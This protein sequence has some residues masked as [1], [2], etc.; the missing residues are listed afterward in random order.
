M[1]RSRII[2]IFDNEFAK[3]G[4]SDSLQQIGFVLNP[5]SLQE[6]APARHAGEIQV[7]L[8]LPRDLDITIGQLRARFAHSTIIA[9]RHIES[10]AMRINALLAG[11]DSCYDANISY[12]EVAAA[13]QSAQRKLTLCQPPA[14]SVPRRPD[15]AAEPAAA[16]QSWRLCDNEWTLVSPGGA[17][18]NLTPMERTVLKGMHGHPERVIRRAGFAA[19]G[20]D[21]VGNGRALDLV[22]SRLKRKGV[23]AGMA[24]PI[25]SLRGKGYAFSATLVQDGSGA[26]HEPT[27]IRKEGAVSPLLAAIQGDRLRFHYQPIVTAADLE[28]VGAEALLR[29]R[30]AGG[31][32]MGIDGLLREAAAPE[33]AQALISW[34]LQT[35][36][37]DQARWRQAAQGAALAVNLNIS[38]QSFARRDVVGT[39]LR[40]IAACGQASGDIR[41]ELTEEAALHAGS[42]DI[43]STLEAFTGRGIQVWLDDFG[44][45]YNN[46][47]W[48]STLPL[49]GLKLDK[50]IV[51]SAARQAEAQKVMTS[52]C[53]LARDLDIV[54]VAQGIETEAHCRAAREAGC[55]LLQGFL[56]FRPGTGDELAAALVEQRWRRADI[57][58]GREHPAP[59]AAL[60]DGGAPFSPASGR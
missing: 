38:P 31:E 53:Q 52:I 41:I 56:F 30:V 39:V 51:W 12:S 48:L 27:V 34:S 46:L 1:N 40:G 25:R 14:A 17:A 11:A 20:L 45:G 60:R 54:T 58:R 35:I 8:C 26:S 24:I 15:A 47:E 6:P 28:I 29:W 43:R 49:T 36:A 22:I 57:A 7:H 3:Q 44:K 50:S 42:A 19:A 2:L 16:E 4:I 5:V 55:D 21:I 10:P 33:A 9:I 23:A 32:T 18:V 13:I 59:A 37:R